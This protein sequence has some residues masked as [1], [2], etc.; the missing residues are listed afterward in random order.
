VTAHRIRGVDNAAMLPNPGAVVYG[1]I[2]I[3]AL[4]AAESAKRETYAATVGAV[5]IA[6]LVYW[7]A[8]TYSEFTGRALER[9]QPLT[10]NSLARTLVHEL[11]IVVGAAV[12]FFALL[13]CWVAG[14]RLT[15]AVVAA[16][17]TSAATIV[18][19]EVVAGVRA[20]LST[21]ALLAQT[22]VGT[23]FGLCMIA[24][25]LILH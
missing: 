18:I 19:V 10:A 2:T 16:V 5:A 11:T 24:L 13:I 21:R 25:E 15:S 17:W 14:V 4:L 7:L 6:L 20:K 8:H 1:T 12:P 9:R 22:A 23:L 3:G